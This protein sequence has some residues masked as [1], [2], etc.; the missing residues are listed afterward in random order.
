VNLASF[1]E[2]L[3]IT[4]RSVSCSIQRFNKRGRQSVWRNI[5]GLQ[6]DDDACDLISTDSASI[7]KIL[8]LL[9]PSD[10]KTRFH[11]LG[12]NSVAAVLTEILRD[13]CTN[14]SLMFRCLLRFIYPCL[15]HQS[16]RR[17][18][19]RN[20]KEGHA[21]LQGPVESVSKETCG[22]STLCC[23]YAVWVDSTDI[24]VPL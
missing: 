1:K 21:F 4:T 8:G 10:S 13:W 14:F 15:C 24:K 18:A 19:F 12:S 3:T 6:S 7:Y 11:I 2:K 22:H 20:T 16:S 5:S 23:C 9:F 17:R